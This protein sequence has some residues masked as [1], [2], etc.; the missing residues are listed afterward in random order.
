MMKKQKR[1]Y[2]IDQKYFWTTKVDY[3]R[4]NNEKAKK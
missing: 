3:L 1:T 4:G 2:I